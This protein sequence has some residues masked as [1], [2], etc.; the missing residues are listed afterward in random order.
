MNLLGSARSHHKND[1]RKNTFTRK[2]FWENP[3]L[4]ELRT[5]ITGINGNDVILLIKLF[6]AF[7]VVKKATRGLFGGNVS[8]KPKN[9]SKEIVYTLENI[10]GLKV[11]DE[12][13]MSIDWERRYKVYEIYHFAAE[14]GVE[15][16]V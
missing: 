5:K 10:E 7:L 14:I 9:K 16:D 2:V 15:V 4:T 8:Y 3:Y 11:G 1:Y 13:M 6:Y 12:V